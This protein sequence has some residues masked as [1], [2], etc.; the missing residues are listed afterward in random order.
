[1]PP[2]YGWQIIMCQNSSGTHLSLLITVLLILAWAVV[3]HY[4]VEIIHSYELALFYTQ[5]I[6]VISFIHANYQVWSVYY[7]YLL[8]IIITIILT[9]HFVKFVANGRTAS[10]NIC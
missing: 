8:I 7:Y 4:C 3:S 1:M 2:C 10:M 5:D 6:E 9:E